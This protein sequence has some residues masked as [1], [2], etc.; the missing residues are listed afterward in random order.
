MAEVVVR[1]RVAAPAERVF[2]VLAD[3]A[4]LADLSP[5]IESCT[6]EGEGV[7]AV[8]TLRMAGGLSLQERLE[9]HDAAAR[10]FS[11]SII[12]ENPLPFRDYLST[13][14]V[15]PDGADAC[16]VDWRGR[17]EPKGDDEAGPA[18]IVHGIYAGGLAALG[19]HLGVAVEDA[20]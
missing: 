12:G 5:A 18:G 10:R 20:D 4:G 3:F 16:R 2:A 14:T 19:K 13:V 1:R 17:F 9:S 15:E 8:R 7:G 11:Y 6:V